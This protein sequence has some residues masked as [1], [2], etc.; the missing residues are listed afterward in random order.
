MKETNKLLIH[1][2][3]NGELIATVDNT[4]Y[5]VNHNIRF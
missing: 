2:A 1:A 5:T 3:Q 4:G